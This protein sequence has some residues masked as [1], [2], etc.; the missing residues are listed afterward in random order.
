[1]HH[2]RIKNIVQEADTP[3]IVSR[4]LLLLGEIYTKKDLRVF[5]VVVRGYFYCQK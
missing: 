1:M 5:A 3:D 4:L 2:Q